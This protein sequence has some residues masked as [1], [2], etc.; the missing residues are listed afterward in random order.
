M[1]DPTSA[2]DPSGA[3]RPPTV[4]ALPTGYV[5][6]VTR[7]ADVIFERSF[8]QQYIDI[9]AALDGFDARL[10][11]LQSGGGNRTPFV[12]R[13]DR[14]LEERGWGKRN[15]TI[16]KTIDGERIS[17]VR[18]HEIDMFAAGSDVQPY[19]GIAVEMEWS[20]KDPF[21][22]RDL[23]N[24]AALHREGALAVG[25]IVTR[26]PRLQ[27]LIKPV[28]R[29]RKGE[30]KYGESTTHWNKLT[31]RVNLGGGGECPLLL[32]G[33]EP[34]RIEGIESAQEV[35][36]RLADIGVL[37]GNWREHYPTWADARRELEA[38]RADAMNLLQPAG[39]SEE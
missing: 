31:P 14:S 1:T 38:L 2:T 27:E 34:E 8:P 17:S 18:G 25:V 26:G 30:E 39:D 5:Y 24:F 3:V 29:N 16:G 37:N 6:G 13:F 28:I 35:Q 32:V 22:D 11:E 9:V 20:N 33:I 19:P 21:F 10:A 36:S 15:I 23:V 4:T 12:A 7:Y